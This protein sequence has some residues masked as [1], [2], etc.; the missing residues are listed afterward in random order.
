MAVQNAQLI[1]FN[2]GIISK[3]AEARVD[4]A[5]MR[6][7]AAEQTNWMPRVFGPMMLRAGLEYK[8][9][10]LNNIVVKT[11]PF[12]RATNDAQILEASDL[13]LRPLVNEAPIT[14]VSV[15]TTVTN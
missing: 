5:R 1:A 2:R 6:Y 4:L 13:L 7:S 9:G 12:I 10:T 3:Y 14:R 11:I 15:G 8:L